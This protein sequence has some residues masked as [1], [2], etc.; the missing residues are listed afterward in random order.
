MMLRLALRSLAVRPW[1]TAVLAAGFGLG[2]AVMVAL[3][4]VGEVII[5][6]A[7]SPALRGGGDL[8]V[9]AAFGPVE[10]ARYLLAHVLGAPAVRAQQTAASPTRRARLYLIA[11]GLSIPVSARGGIPSL[12]R[13]VG[14]LEVAGVAAWTDTAA[15]GSWSHPP[16][17]DVLRA[18]DRFH[19][20][21]GSD[22]ADLP[23]PA[24][25]APRGL[26][27]VVPK[28]D[29][30]RTSWAE[31]LYFNGRSADG[32]LRF[33][34]TFLA[35]A[36]AQAGP[37]VRP[38][39]PISPGAAGPEGQ[40][41]GQ[42]SRRQRPAFVRLQLERDGQSTNY[43]A[44]A[45][46]DDA[47]LV[48]RAPDLDIAG[49]RVR[50]EGSQYR[51]TLAL[52]QEGDPRS[53]LDGELVLDA[54]PGRSLPPTAIH[55]AR[56]WVSGYVV[57]V[58]SGALHGRLRAGGETIDLAGATGYHDHNWG[59][60][61]GVRWQWGQV[62]DGDLSIVFGRV[63][64][65]A[66]VADPERT[67]GVL[68]VL[69]PNGPLGFATDVSIEETPTPHRVTIR[70]RGQR[71]NIMLA[72]A[73]EETVGTRMGLTRQANGQTMTFLQLG[74]TYRVTGQLGDRTVDFTA[75]GSAE[76]FRSDDS[77]IPTP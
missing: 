17:E 43:S 44:G 54:P 48:A 21:P 14:D 3:L 45:L 27:P 61:E 1:R 37:G 18:M 77:R 31:W 51:L 7:H 60:W 62:A 5:E 57:P 53:R 72:L 35:G 58:L 70:A 75:R 71:L 38:Q 29:S 76:T 10:N 59:F 55:G 49:N 26:T 32:R 20:V 11:P 42:R 23:P 12:E 2:I 68:A 28:P 41:P 36:P 65:P 74:G 22:P 6:Q 40:T 47:D 13:A 34:L 19:A 63:F 50:L 73:V 4:G 39:D 33:Y 64:P 69:G 15:D 52:A 16:P 8:V 24:S 9:S 30:F 66:S 67:P 46:V 56:G 25:A